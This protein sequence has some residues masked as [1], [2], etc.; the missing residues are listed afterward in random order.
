MKLL[1]RIIGIGSIGFG[2]LLFASIWEMSIFFSGFAA[3]VAVICIIGG[4]NLL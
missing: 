1:K 3:I 4:A 2:V